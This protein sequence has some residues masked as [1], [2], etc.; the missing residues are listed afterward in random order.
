MK[1]RLVLDFDGVCHSYTSVWKGIDV[2]ADPPVDGL[3]EFLEEAKEVFDIAIYSTRSKEQA[4]RD[5]MRKWFFEH[6]N[7]WLKE[8][9]KMPARFSEIIDCEWLSFP[10][11][12]PLAWVGID[13]RVITFDGIWPDVRALENFKPWNKRPSIP[14]PYPL[15]NEPD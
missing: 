15:D 2:I 7:A 10:S 6:Y 5:A 1:K 12:K 4:G 11:K 3:F 9:G 13:D 14:E 8:N